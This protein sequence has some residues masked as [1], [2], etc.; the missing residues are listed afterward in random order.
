MK[1]VSITKMQ[2][3]SDQVCKLLRVISNPDRLMIIFLL[4]KGEKCVGEIEESL[5]I[6]QPTLSQQ[7]AVLRKENLV[8]TRRVGKNIY[9]QLEGVWALHVIQTLYHQNVKSNKI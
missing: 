8:S 9:Y 1:A 2:R 6:L 7:L 3:A 5:C 4:S